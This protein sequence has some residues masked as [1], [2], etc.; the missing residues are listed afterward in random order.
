ME[1]DTS[2]FWA[3]NRC[4]RQT[5]GWPQ[6]DASQHNGCFTYVVHSSSRTLPEQREQKVGHRLNSSPKLYLS[7]TDVELNLSVWSCRKGWC[8][9]TDNHVQTWYPLRRRGERVGSI[10]ERF[11]SLEEN[12]NPASTWSSAFLIF[13]PLP[14]SNTRQNKSL[15]LFPYFTSALGNTL[16]YLRTSPNR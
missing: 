16:T 14:P 7:Q 13:L 8:S 15:R 1:S 9:I 4:P 3:G 5:E 10:S 11:A 6:E 2:W 12:T